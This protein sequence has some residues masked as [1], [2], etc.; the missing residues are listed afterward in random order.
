MENNN[1]FLKMNQENLTTLKIRYNYTTKTFRY[2]GAKEWEDDFDFSGYNKDFIIE[3]ILTDE[4]V[5]YNSEQMKILF[6]S[7]GIKSYV[8]E[9]EKLMSQGRHFGMDFYYLKKYD[10]RFIMH[11]HS[12]KRGLFNKSHAIMAGG[13]R[14]HLPGTAEID[15]IKDGLNLARGMSY[16][17]IA[18]DLPAGGCKATVQMESL[19]LN[20][21]EVM[22]FLA[23]TLDL[24]RDMTAP[25]MNLP[26]EMSD[27]MREKQFT[28]QYTGGKYSQTG[29]T[30]RATAYGLILTM[31]E[32]VQFVEGKASL[33]G[34]RVVLI[35]FGAVG[36]PVAEY[37]L[38][39]GAELILAV[40]HKEKAEAFAEVHSYKHIRI[41]NADEA[42]KEEADILCPCAA[43]GVISY[44]DIPLLKCKYIWGAANNQLKT[45][46]PEDE[47]EMAQMMADRGLLF[48][49]E[50][51]HNCAGIMC[52]AEGYY[53]NGNEN[54]LQEKI[55]RILPQNTRKILMIAKEKGITPTKA[56][57]DYCN[58]LLY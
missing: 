36:R 50:W 53:Y 57:Y 9:I 31:K 18:A 34:K 16:K 11:Q 2:F 6:E 23:Y 12:R 56:C 43:G 10:I 8:E 28:A 14:R 29:L 21:L 13:I 37:L 27:V 24:C 51:W 40:R 39:E 32:A 58:S 48:Q 49:P 38:Q 44:E 20:N 22:A 54:S 42:L 55:R 47:L 1:I 17:N 19:D 3:D 15:A 46:R 26:A 33:E 41:V 45:D 7:C 52:G 4:P 30:G 35:G 25:D 5:F